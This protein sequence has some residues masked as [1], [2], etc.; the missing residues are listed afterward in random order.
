MSRVMRW[1]TFVIAFLGAAPLVAQRSPS[2]V[3][4]TIA[5][6]VIGPDS[7][8]VRTQTS[9]WMWSA[10]RGPMTDSAG[11]MFPWRDFLAV[12]LDIHYGDAF[13]QPPESSSAGPATGVESASA[14][15]PWDLRRVMRFREQSELGWIL[16]IESLVQ[17][18]IEPMTGGY[19]LTAIEAARRDTSVAVHFTQFSPQLERAA[20]ELSVRLLEHWARTGAARASGTR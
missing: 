10:F 16:R 20:A 3:R 17:I 5:Y 19:R 4:P 11:P 8:A 13:E 18:V 14:R 1:V 12:G 2:G 7:G 6:F 9:R 15:Y